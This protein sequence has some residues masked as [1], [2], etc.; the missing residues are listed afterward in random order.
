M[1]ISDKIRGTKIVDLYPNVCQNLYGLWIET[2]FYDFGHIWGKEGE[3]YGHL[4]LV[5]VQEQLVGA[6]KHTGAKS[7]LALDTIQNSDETLPLVLGG[8]YAVNEEVIDQARTAYKEQGSWA[9]MNLE[10]LSVM[11]IRFLSE[12][13]TFDDIKRHAIE[14]RNVKCSSQIHEFY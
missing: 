6:I 4:T 14:L 12:K 1:S 3:L 7:F 5:Y 8:V 13:K 9:K 2:L 11:P 10:Q